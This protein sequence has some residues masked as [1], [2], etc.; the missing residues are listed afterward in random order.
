M[1]LPEYLLVESKKLAAERRVPPARV[2]EESLR[3]Y[4]TE[5]RQGGSNASTLLPILREPVL[6]PGVDL[7]DTS[8]I[9]ELERSSVV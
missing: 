2:F 5:Q 3:A 7:N 8:R 4:L 6:V 9:W 1:D